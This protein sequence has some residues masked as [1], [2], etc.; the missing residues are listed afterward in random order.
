MVTFMVIF[1]SVG[2]YLKTKSVLLTGRC[3]DDYVFVIFGKHPYGR[4]KIEAVQDN[5]T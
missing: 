4:R 3:P 1:Q 5:M 2:E